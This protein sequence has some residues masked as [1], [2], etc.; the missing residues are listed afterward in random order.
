MKIVLWCFNHVNAEY[1]ENFDKTENK[2]IHVLN[3]TQVGK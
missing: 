1:Q 2:V 3:P